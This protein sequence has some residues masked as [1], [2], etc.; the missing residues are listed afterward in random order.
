MSQKLDIIVI[1]DFYHNVDDVREFALQQKFDVTG[2]FPG[3][4]TKSMINDIIKEAI[5]YVVYPWGGKVTNWFDDK[6]TGAFQY[7]TEEH[8]SWIHSDG[9]ND[10]AAVLYLTPNAPLS[11]GTAFYRHKQTKEDRYIHKTETPTEEDLKHPYLRDYKDITKWEM[12]D[13]VSNKYN[14]LVLYRASLFHKSL[15]YFGKGLDDGR[16]FQVFFFNGYP[17]EYDY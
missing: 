11:A 1:D 10:W 7:T 6:Y 15:D 9:G 12:T 8:H 3:Y 16:L 5:E 13:Y 2:N 14:R 17:Q 4:R